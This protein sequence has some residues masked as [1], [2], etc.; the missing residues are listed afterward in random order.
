MRPLFAA[1]L[2]TLVLTVPAFAGPITQLVVLG[3][4]LSDTGNV[5]AATGGMTPPA[6]YFQGRFSN[7]PVWVE[8]FADRLGVARPTPSLLGGTNYAWAGATT[9]PAF[10][11]GEVPNMVAQVGQ[12]LAGNAPTPTTLYAVWGG[13][14]DLLNGQTDPT[15][16]AAFLAA[17]IAALAN[18]GGKQFL[19]PNLP[20][21]GD[22]PGLR[23]TPLQTPLDNLTAAFD[24]ALE[25]Q[26]RQLERDRGIT[27]F[28]LDT[29]GLVGEVRANPGQ[30]GF[31]N[32]T[33]G[34]LN[35]GD[36]SGQGYL[37]WDD[38]HPTTAAHRIIADRAAAAVFAPAPPSM[39]LLAVG[40]GLLGWRCRR[41]A[42]SG[43]MLS[44]AG[45]APVP[46]S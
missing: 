15:V 19:V 37:F 31:T 42:G 25:A 3:D 46:G 5:F 43:I 4:S 33:Q 23:G 21:L 11:G 41:R 38:V 45:R 12:Y 22:L 27:I 16:P 28:R 9:G 18:A 13:A 24:A 8:Q 10:D 30:F 26:L 2:G 29:A 39:V 6:P 32:T 20:P 34:A 36:L 7:G 17:E 1:L 35:N 40:A 44:A 14:N